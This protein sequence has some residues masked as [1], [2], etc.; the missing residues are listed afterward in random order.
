VDDSNRHAGP[1]PEHGGSE[2]RNVY[3]G[4]DGSRCT[5]AKEPSGDLMFTVFLGKVD[6]NPSKP[7]DRPELVQCALL[8]PDFFN[9]RHKQ[10]TT[11]IIMT[12]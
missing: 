9:I 7:L 5:V 10:K 3:C 4:G 2:C 1:G 6:T 11:Y 12:V 8:P